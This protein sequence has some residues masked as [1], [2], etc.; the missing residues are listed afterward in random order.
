MT[1]FERCCWNKLLTT[2]EMFWIAW[3]KLSRMVIIFGVYKF[4]LFMNGICANHLFQASPFLRAIMGSVP[5][6][7]LQLWFACNMCHCFVRT[8]YRCGN[9]RRYVTDKDIHR[10]SWLFCWFSSC[11]RSSSS[12]FGFYCMTTT[13]L[14][15]LLTNCS[16]SFLEWLQQSWNVEHIHR[17]WSAWG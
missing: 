17:I 5:K 6:V 1:T 11:F 2:K 8:S 14:Y 9:S 15:L 7:F 4:L 3:D 16:I 13:F 12:T 10:L